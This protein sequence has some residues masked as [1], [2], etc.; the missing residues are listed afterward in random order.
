VVTTT[1]WLALQSHSYEVARSQL[2]P[3]Y[4]LAPTDLFDIFCLHFRFM[5][6]RISHKWSIQTNKNSARSAGII[7]LQYTLTPM[8]APPVTVMFS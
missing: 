2:P 6:P 8:V 1:N 4:F 5:Y 7:V 3:N